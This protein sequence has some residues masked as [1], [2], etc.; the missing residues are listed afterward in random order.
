MNKRSVE[1]LFRA[2]EC[3]TACSVLHCSRF[4]RVCVLV[5]LTSD[6]QTNGY[7]M[8]GE[9]TIECDDAGRKYKASLEEPEFG[10]TPEAVKATQSPAVAVAREDEGGSRISQKVRCNHGFAL[11]NG[12]AT[13]NGHEVAGNS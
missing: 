7:A 9:L 11:T 8:T 1:P 12:H 4:A 13:E 10:R 2:V 6:A 3:L 5:T